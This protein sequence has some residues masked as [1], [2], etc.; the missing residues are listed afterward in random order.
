[1]AV[2]YRFDCTSCEARVGVDEY[3]RT[4]LLDEGCPLCEARVTTT[5]FA[6]FSYR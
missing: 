2:R 3:V 5:A 1:M 4:L 6:R